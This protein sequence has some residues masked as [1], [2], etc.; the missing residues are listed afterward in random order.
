MSNWV[1]NGI[2]ELKEWEQRLLEVLSKVLT[3]DQI[4]YYLNEFKRD[5]YGL[6][7]R[8]KKGEGVFTNSL[9]NGISGL[10]QVRSLLK[11]LDEPISDAV[12]LE[13]AARFAALCFQ[14]GIT[15]GMFTPGRAAECL[16]WSL[17][18]S[19][20][21]FAEKIKLTEKKAIRDLTKRS[22]EVRHQPLRD[23]KT[24]AADVARNLW[25][26]G[27]KLLHHEMATYL[28]EEYQEEGKHPFLR[29]P[30]VKEENTTKLLR[31]VTKSVA[32]DMNRLDLIKGLK[33]IP[34]KA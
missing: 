15:T 34:P 12:P 16:E 13:Q 5:I 28:V 1:E 6:Y 20:K 7:E 22:I 23:A 26:N 30:G 8:A 29:L 11:E 9:F 19:K 18:Q 32:K 31:E 24:K 25:E 3:A 33:K 10:S 2:K 14:A 4:S 17:N 21:E 27:S